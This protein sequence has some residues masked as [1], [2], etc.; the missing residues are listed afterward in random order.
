MRK[1]GHFLFCASLSAR[2]LSAACTDDMQHHFVDDVV[3]C[4]L[5]QEEWHPLVSS[6]QTCASV[7][8]RASKGDS[9]ER[10]EARTSLMY[11]V[12]VCSSV[13]RPQCEERFL[14][15]RYTDVPV[16]WRALHT[17]AILISSAATVHL[18]RCDSACTR[19][20]LEARVRDLDLALIMSGTP[21]HEREGWVHSLIAELQQHLLIP[22]NQRHGKSRKCNTVVD[23]VRKPMFDAAAKQC[24]H[25][26]ERLPSRSEFLSFCPS[27]KSTS[28][29]YGHPFIVRGF[30]K[31]WPA[32]TR[33]RDGEDLCR[34]AG[35][36][37][38]VP[39]E[40][41]DK[42]TDSDWGQLIVPWREFLR[43]IGWMDDCG[44][45]SP[46]ERLY[47]A[48][49]S[50][51][52]QFPWLLHD[53]LVPDY[54]YTCPPVP[55][56]MP[57]RASDDMDPII[58]VWLGPESTVSPAHTDPYYNCYVQVVGHKHVWVA[59]PNM[60]DEMQVYAAASDGKKHVLVNKERTQTTATTS[61]DGESTDS[62][63][64][65]MFTQLMNNTSQVDVFSSTPLPAGFVQNV[66]PHAQHA[67][68]HPG[69]MLFMPP[70]W[71]HALQS[72][73]K[74]RIVSGTTTETNRI[75]FFRV[76]LVLKTHACERSMHSM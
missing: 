36:G 59:P 69:D 13:I 29:P 17:D 12:E 30:A 43:R 63:D 24:I 23:S 49:H 71:W 18:I 15:Y 6:L 45:H 64:M 35:P 54:V 16:A 41:G 28:Y 58:S 47:L 27:G 50:L 52:T 40:R 65:D 39:V 74:V 46:N 14:I 8:Q 31:D 66:V 25:E 5:N 42:Y 4:V 26:C 60:T 67:E 44:D 75:E 61:E 19:R 2:A 57:E 53:I 34:R 72:T 37:R 11:V 56:Y 73:S 51:H 9:I 32:I 1:F 70:L 33:W 68:L 62:D 55:L 3:E 48:Q 20:F 38:V 21:G 7:I 10:S 76:I 22:D